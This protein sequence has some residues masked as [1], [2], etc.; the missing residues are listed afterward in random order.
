MGGTTMIKP[1]TGIDLSSSRARSGLTS[2]GELMPRLIR[3]YEL[4]ADL[5][6]Q[7]GECTAS[8]E[9]EYRHAP[10]PVGEVPQVQ[11]TFAWF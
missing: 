3:S 2:I 8:P 9:L 6:Q 5:M 1:V 11:A 4:Q 10:I 7:K